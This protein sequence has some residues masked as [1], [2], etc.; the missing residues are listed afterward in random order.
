MT[1]LETATMD[2]VAGTIDQPNVL[3]VK[4]ARS[5]SQRLQGDG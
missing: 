1:D 2:D 3:Q 4:E 5:E